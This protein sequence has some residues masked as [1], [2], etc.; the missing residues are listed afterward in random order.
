MRRENIGVLVALGLVASSSPVLAGA[1]QYLNPNFKTISANHRLVAVLPFKVTID[2]KNLK[3]V[4]PEMLVQMEKDE[5][6]EFQKQIYIRLLERSQS[7]GYTVGFQD[8]D[9][10]LAKLQQGGVS[11]D[12]IS[13]H[14]MDE[15]AKLLGVDA[16]ISGTI[17]QSR[18]TGTGTAMVET[19]LF[20]FGGSTARVD[21]NVAIHNGAD[22][23]LLWD[24]DHTDSGGG[25]TGSMT[26]S[27]EAMTKSLMKKVAGSFPY[28]KDLVA[29]K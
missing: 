1:Q 2:A 7:E 21:I 13:A 16:V 25:L 26:N 14:G 27:T 24:Y 18:P 8:A 3:D 15:I 28:R 12:S 11:L 4:S 19:V 20:G 23:Q 6:V 5:A 10:T 22:G 17:H 9:Q 29:A